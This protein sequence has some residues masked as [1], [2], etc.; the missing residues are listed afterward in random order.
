M[1]YYKLS[2]GMSL[3]LIKRE[4]GDANAYYAPVDLTIRVVEEW[5]YS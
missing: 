3:L 5:S 4:R 1:M 2:F